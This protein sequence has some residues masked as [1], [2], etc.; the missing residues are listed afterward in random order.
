MKVI[1]FSIILFIFSLFPFYTKAQVDERCH[2]STEGKDFWFGFMGNRFRGDVH[3]LEITVSSRMGADLTITYGPNEMPIETRTVGVNQ[4]V[5]IIIDYGLL[6]PLGSEIIEDKG[7][8][9]VSTQP[10]SVYALNY[11]TQSSDVALIYP[12]E[13]LGNEYFAMCYTPNPTNTVESNSEF[14]IVATVDNT[15][16]EIT[17]SVDTDMGKKANVRFSVTINQGQSYQ[18]QSMNRDVAG[19]GDLTGSHIISDQPIAFYSGAKSTSVPFPLSTSGVSRDHLYEQIPPLSTWGREFYLVPLQLRS[20]DTYRIL[21]AEDGTSII[22]EGLNRTIAL[23]R[24]QYAEFELSNSQASR[25]ISNKKI[26]LAQY[27]RYQK[28]DQ[29]SGV[30]DPFMIIISPVIQKINDIT[31]EAYGSELITDIF[32][33]NIITLTSEVEAILYDGNGIQSYFRPFPDGNYS[34]AQV[35]IAKGTHRLNNDHPEGGFLAFVYGFG[36]LNDT[37]SYGYGVGFNLD[38]Q[39]D[40]AGTLHND[41]IVICPGIE[42]ELDA[43]NYFN[44]YNW[45]NGSTGSSIM[46]SEEGQYWVTASTKLGCVKSDTVYIKVDHPKIDLGKDTGSCNPGEIVLDAGPAFETYLWQDGSTSQ[47]F[48]VQTTGQYII[49]GTNSFGC[50]A[51]DTVEV[52]VFDPAFSQNFTVATDLHPDISFFNQTEHAVSYLWDFGDGETSEVKNPVHHYNSVGEYIVVLQ[53]T[54]NDGCIETTNSI[55]KII[56]FK[57]FTPNA[58]RPD[59]EISENRIFRPVSEGIDPENY[60]FQIFNRVGSTVFETQNPEA[61]WD[62]NMPNATPAGPAIYVWV[63]KFMDLQGYHHIQKGTVMLVR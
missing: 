23:N 41:T 3:K 19:Q 45:S 7:I 8:H 5:S 46:V 63:V 24:G 59:S 60:K 17:P 50:K 34:Y 52:F 28:A 32:F 14:L 1:F 62:G 51:S 44:I 39:L 4:S 16:V 11:R 2:Y 29:S 56:P 31:F 26:L 61:C 13:S 55:V 15:V 49:T 21:A 54:S 35:P 38:I 57:L 12:T 30:G 33:V 43:G 37:E 6:E 25:I 10:V 58:F 47:T 42:Y 18:V 9:L 27:C 48:I 53:A 36:P 20:K 40:I 22:V